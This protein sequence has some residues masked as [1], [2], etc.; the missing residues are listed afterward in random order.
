V[1]WI[2]KL[3]I[4]ILIG[5]IIVFFVSVFTPNQKASTPTTP[6]RQG[7]AMQAGNYNN[8]RWFGDGIKQIKDAK[9][10]AQASDALAI[11]LDR[12]KRDPMLLAAATNQILG[13]NITK[14]ALVSNGWSTSLAIQSATEIEVA[15]GRSKVSVANAPINGYNSGVY[16]G[17]VV[18]SANEG[19]SGD[20]KGVEVTLPNQKKFW[21]LGRCGNIALPEK[22]SLPQGKTDNPTPT[23][24]EQPIITPVI[25]PVPTPK[26]TPIPTPTPTPYYRSY[27]G[28]SGGGGP[29]LQPK[30]NDPAVGYRTLGND[31]TKGAG[32]DI[33]GPKPTVTSAPL[34]TPAPVQ[35]S[36]SSGGGRVSESSASAPGSTS[37]AA[38]PGASNRSSA[39]SSGGSSAA[40]AASRPIAAPAAPP[41][42]STGNP[43][44]NPFQ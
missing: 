38:A 33:Q 32:T 11:W 31:G 39:N 26:P 42:A 25:T 1:G 12:V 34:M 15:I 14:D 35:V 10:D 44:V 28:S 18:A 6:S 2:I 7:W 30:S 9:T 8:N 22:P 19:I 24:T 3:A 16:N 20:R 36:R 40:P 5:L 4:G 29:Y 13:K 43:I 17:T 37:G 21:V 41:N 23:T 27:G